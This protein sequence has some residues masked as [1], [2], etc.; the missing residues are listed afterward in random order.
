M[1]KGGQN[2]SSVQEGIGMG[3]HF[4]FELMFSLFGEGDTHRHI[5]IGQRRYIHSLS[6]LS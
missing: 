1:T 6:K 3:M 4:T 2:L 5:Y